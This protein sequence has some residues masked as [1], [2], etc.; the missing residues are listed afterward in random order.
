M[1]ENNEAANGCLG[2]IVLVVVVVGFIFWGWVGGIAAFFIM[3]VVFFIMGVVAGA[4]NQSPATADSPMEKLLASHLEKLLALANQ[5]DAVAQNKLGVMYANGKGVPKDESK[6]VEWYRKAADQG[7]AGAQNNLGVMYA[8][9]RGVSKDETK[10]VEWYRKAADQGLAEAQNNLKVL[11]ERIKQQTPE[12]VTEQS[13]ATADSDLEQLLAL[14][15]QGNAHAQFHLG[16]K[17]ENGEGVLKDETKAVECYRKA[18]EQGY[19]EAQYNL[20]Q[21]Y[22]DGRG[23]P[24]DV[25]E[26]RKWFRLAAARGHASA[27]LSYTLAESEEKRQEFE[28]TLRELFERELFERQKSKPLT[29]NRASPGEE[30]KP[31]RPIPESASKQEKDSV[32]DINSADYDALLGLPGIGA[33][34]AKMILAERAT[35][36]SFSSPGELA[37]FLNLPPHKA[38]QLQ[39]RVRFS[40]GAPKPPPGA[41]DPADEPQTKY[42]LGGR[43]V[44]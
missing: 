26:A 43:V 36:H 14:A 33:A 12:T 32:V 39:G 25:K 5:G 7:L 27:Q 8:D 21:M 11:S 30:R 19:V 17:Y 4:V 31:A 10:A 18:A 3:V 15:N 29:T 38:A 42:R 16:L 28:I 24:R 22:Y 20:G 1:A 6:A 41:D 34:E 37:E 13:P 35:G 44:D 23:V 9:G 2:F 40:A